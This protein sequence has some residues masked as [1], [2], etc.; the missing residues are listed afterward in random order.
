MKST[1]IITEKKEIELKED[2]FYGNANLT[3]EQAIEIAKMKPV[4]IKIVREVDEDGMFIRSVSVK[5]KIYGSIDY[6][7]ITSNLLT[8]NRDCAEK[9]FE[10][11]EDA[12]KWVMEQIENVKKKRQKIL[13]NVEK[14]K[15]Y[16]SKEVLIIV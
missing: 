16:E 8:N 6:S 14:N 4:L 2:Y 3:N 12:E 15:N 11:I 9:S 5:T 10:N 13:E 7:E 1:V